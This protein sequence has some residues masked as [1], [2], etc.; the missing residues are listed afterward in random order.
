[1]SAAEACWRTLMYNLNY[2]KPKTTR[3]PVHV[4][5]CQTIVFRGDQK[6]K[7]ILNKNTKTPMTDF[8]ELNKRDESWKNLLYHQVPQFFV[9]NKVKLTWTSRLKPDESIVGR[10]YFV[11]PADYE[12]Y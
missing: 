5:N 12:R 11:H 7:E 2:Q 10:M 4:E 6:L 9:W 1:M 3:L 8:F